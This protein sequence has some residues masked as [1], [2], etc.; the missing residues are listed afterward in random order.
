MGTFPGGEFP[1]K[2]ICAWRAEGSRKVGDAGGSR[3]ARV[4]IVEG[5]ETFLTGSGTAPGAGAEASRWQHELGAALWWHV[6]RMAR[7]QADSE[8]TLAWQ[9][10]AM[11]SGVAA[12]AASRKRQRTDS[13]STAIRSL[14]RL[15]FMSSSDCQTVARALIQVNESRFVAAAVEP[16]APLTK[17]QDPGNFSP[18]L[19][20]RHKVWMSYDFHHAPV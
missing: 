4:K 3:P 10:C 14:E 8:A 13:L 17:A 2:C 9:A 11:L 6:N 20:L 5:P 15:R 7:Q 1:P 12:V 18:A 19:R 16:A